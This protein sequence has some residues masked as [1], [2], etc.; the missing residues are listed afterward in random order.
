[1]I[2]VKWYAAIA[3][4]K[5]KISTTP[6]AAITIAATGALG[7]GLDDFP[8]ISRMNAVYAYF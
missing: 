1:M 4:F 5:G 8:V 6:T 3:I 2:G 7:N